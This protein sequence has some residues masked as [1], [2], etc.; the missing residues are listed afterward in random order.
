[1]RMVSKLPGRKPNISCNAGFFYHRS[2]QQKGNWASS[3]PNVGQKG[4]GAISSPNVGEGGTARHEKWQ[5]RQMFDMGLDN[6]AND[7]AS[8]R[9]KC[10]STGT[11]Y[12]G[13]SMSENNG[14][15]GEEKISGD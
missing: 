7:I 9:V 6:L 1:M 2:D 8:S 3:S 11:H 15:V 10:H 5:V 14:S 12:S 4:N 13:S